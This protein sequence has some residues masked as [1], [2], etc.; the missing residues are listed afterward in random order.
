MSFQLIVRSYAPF[1]SFGVPAF[2]GDH[3]G[4]TTS[5]K[6]TARLAAW[7]TFDPAKGTVGKPDA[8]A[9]RRSS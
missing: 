3:R 1:K 2:H 5:A 9:T 8:S 4:P 6:V 7:V